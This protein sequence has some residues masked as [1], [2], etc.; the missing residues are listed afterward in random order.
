MLFYKKS[1]SQWVKWSG[2]SFDNLLQLL[3]DLIGERDTSDIEVHIFCENIRIDPKQL[4]FFEKDEI[5]VLVFKRCV[6]NQVPVA[7]NAVNLSLIDCRVGSYTSLSQCLI[8]EMLVIQQCQLN[9]VPDA[10]K[11]L[12]CLNYLDISNN[13]EISKLHWWIENL[14]LKFLSIKQNNVKELPLLPNTIKNLDVSYNKI[15][16]LDP[17]LSVLPHLKNIIVSQNPL[18]FPPLSVTKYT[19][20]ML[21]GYLKQYLGKTE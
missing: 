2:E 6:L 12:K 14:Q 3:A 1:E 9:K 20:Q 13:K 4:V 10:L 16:K 21:L 11:D 7:P 18:E 15:Q 5:K 19:T 8:M 17:W